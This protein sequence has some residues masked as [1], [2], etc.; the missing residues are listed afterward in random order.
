[1]SKQ[2][3]I[4]KAKPFDVSA[5][6]RLLWKAY[7]DSDGLYP[8]PDEARTVNWVTQ[9]VSDGF[10][11]VAAKSGRIVGSIAVTNFQFPWSQKWYLYVDWI[12][13]DRQFRDGKV[14]PALL[15]AVHAMADEAQAPIYA[16]VSSGKDAVLKDRLMQTKGY[17]Y[18]GG[19]FIRD[20]SLAT[21]D[22]KAFHQDLSRATD[23]QE[24]THGVIDQEDHAEV[25]TS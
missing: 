2:I 15:S 22:E 9:I 11:V 16:G 12:Y 18:L 13:V 20:L 1:M 19:Q 17:T 24:A 10:V 23:E 14:F 4:R 3:E 7:T 21:D 25:Q 6:C 8:E 5:I